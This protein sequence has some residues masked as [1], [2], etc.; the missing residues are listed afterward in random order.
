M[1]NLKMKNFRILQVTAA[2]GERK[3]N[4]GSFYVKADVEDP[5]NG[6]KEYNPVNRFGKSFV[7]TIRQCFPATGTYLAEDGT[8]QPWN[9]L[10]TKLP[11][12]ITREEIEKSIP[13]THRRIM[14]AV[15]VHVD[16]GGEFARKRGQAG[17]DRDGNPYNADDLILDG[18]GTFSVYTHQDVLTS[19]EYVMVPATDANG[20]L[21]PNPKYDPNDP[22][23]IEEEWMQTVK[24]DANGAPEMREAEG[25]ES[26]PNADGIKRAFMISVEAAIAKCIAE[27]HPERIPYRYREGIDMNAAQNPNPNPGQTGQNPNPNPQAGTG[28]GPT[29]HPTF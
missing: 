1:P 12:D 15:S 3:A 19:M 13:V 23:C 4:V 11:A 26:K 22:D 2:E 27:G 24:K 16:L 21:I 6:T 10:N 8:Q 14:N 18:D 25:W 9:G 20:N 7:N 17:F 28:A 29:P 5:K